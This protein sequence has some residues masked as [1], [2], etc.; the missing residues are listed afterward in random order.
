MVVKS[1]LLLDTLFFVKDDLDGQITDPISSKRSSKSKFI[2]TS[3]P[4][5]PVQYPIISLK[6]VNIEA[7]RIGMQSTLQDIIITLE[8]RIWARNEKEKNDLWEN[9]NKRLA[10]IQF[11][12]STG[13]I[14]KD[15]HDFNVISSVE[16]D[17]EG[18]SGGQVIKSRI[19][20]IQY[21]F[22]DA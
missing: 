19:M 7:F 2:V 15:L 18:E 12:G 9:I 5:R 4:Q 8:I 14:A 3:Y 17:E 13:S 21:M 22:H 20:T 16:L 11:T 1:T 6:A 10:D